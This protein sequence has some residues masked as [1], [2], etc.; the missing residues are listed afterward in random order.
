MAINFV[1][2]LEE[3]FLRR[4]VGRKLVFTMYDN[5]QAELEEW[6]TQL[7]V[8]WMGHTACPA[9]RPGKV[10][11]QLDELVMSHAATL[12]PIL[13][14][15][16]RKLE[17]LVEAI[18]PQLRKWGDAYGMVMAACASN[19]WCRCVRVPLCVHAAVRARAR[20]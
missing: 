12:Q 14:P 5:V 15:V 16:V 10:L 18:G 3:E 20:A 4:D 9:L 1:M 8:W 17:K 19:Q 11:A 7:R 2:V 13:V 6:E